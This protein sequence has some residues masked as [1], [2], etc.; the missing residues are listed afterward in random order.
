[1]DELLTA[2][3]S[4]DNKVRRGAE[5]T[6][7]SAQ[8][9]RGFA[10]ALA[11]ALADGDGDRSLAA[12][13]EEEPKRLMAGVLLQQFVRDRWELA[14]DIVLPREDKTQV[15]SM[16]LTTM[17][18]F[19]ASRAARASAARVVALMAAGGEWPSG[20]GGLIPSLLGQLALAA[21]TVSQAKAGEALSGGGAA[22]EHEVGSD[23]AGA[24]AAP[25]VAGDPV[26]GGV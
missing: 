5:A 17:V 1:M 26:A 7:R 2:A 3:L 4:G 15:R 11:R 16:V 9:H 10:I 25:L 19:S 20:W 21:A 23:G 13:P 18:D 12:R 24:G 6:L 22:M 14:G 8:A